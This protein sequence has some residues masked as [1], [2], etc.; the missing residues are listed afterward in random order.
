[1]ASLLACANALRV[2]PAASRRALVQ[3]AA[4]GALA[5]SSAYAKFNPVD[6]YS[7]ATESAAPP[8]PPAR[9]LKDNLAEAK[10][11]Q[12]LADKVAAQEKLTG[13][14][15]DENDI[16]EL[17]DI[18]RSKYCG[19][20]GLYSNLEGG[21]CADARPAPAYCGKPGLYSSMDSLG[22]EACGEKEADLE[23]R[24]AAAR[25][26]DTGPG[27]GLSLPSFGF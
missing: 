14:T 1:M 10:L 26:K 20:S 21:G 24:R 2:A 7:A 8:A 9:V 23:K 5:P 25:A 15:L 13:Y 3:A 12:I 22:T 19:K 11:R 16:G 27:L 18:L 6:A 17:E 4:A